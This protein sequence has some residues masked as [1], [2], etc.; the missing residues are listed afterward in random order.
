MKNLFKIFF[1]FIIFFISIIIAIDTLVI[2][3]TKEYILDMEHLKEQENIDAIL[4]LGAGLKNNGPSKMLEERLIEA[5]SLYE[6][7][8]STKII[9]SGDHG[10]VNY[11]EVNVM[12][13]Y[14]IDNGIPDDVIFMDHAGFNTY[15]SMYRAKEI[16]GVERMVVVTQEYHL[17]RALFIANSLGIESFGANATKR[18]YSG[19][20]YRD[21]REVLA[22]VKDFYLSIFKPEATILGE[23]IDMKVSADIT[24]DAYIN[25]IS[26]EDGTYHYIKNKEIIFEILSIIDNHDKE[27]RCDYKATYTM[28]INGRKVYDIEILGDIIHI[29]DDDEEIILDEEES[30]II[31]D[32][33]GKE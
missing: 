2:G 3:N 23:K 10:R 14:L 22:R 19:Q 7:G 8:I 24:D 33:I 15:D 12:K 9:V 25:I 16:F 27:K 32:I 21:V 28:K 5:I 11:D 30:K 4:V 6:E 26:I 18:I 17:Y 20:I 31:L 1:S 29:V 13:Q